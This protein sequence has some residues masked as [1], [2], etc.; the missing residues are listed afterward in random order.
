MSSSGT[1][2]DSDAA[3]LPTPGTRREVWREQAD[4]PEPQDDCRTDTEKIF[5]SDD[6]FFVHNTGHLEETF[7]VT[8]KLKLLP[9][10][11]LP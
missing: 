11:P 8:Q 9:K 2:Q 10:T 4:M 7:S 3:S 5:I 1:G 6:F